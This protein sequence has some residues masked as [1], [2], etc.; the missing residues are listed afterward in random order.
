MVPGFVLLCFSKV[1]IF[2]ANIA[3]IAIL[4]I[5]TYGEIITLDNLVEKIKHYQTYFRASGGGV[6]LSGGEPLLH[7]PCLEKTAFRVHLPLL[8][9]LTRAPWV[10]IFL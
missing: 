9:S 10:L 8:S 2:V 4:G 3:I 7:H 1:V 6:T 5:V